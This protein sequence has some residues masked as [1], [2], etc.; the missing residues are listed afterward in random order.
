MNRGRNRTLTMRVVLL[1]MAAV[2][3][4]MTAE[5]QVRLVVPEESPSGPY[6]ARLERGVLLE[7]D[8]WVAI[9]F[10]RDPACVRPNFNLLNFF[11]FVNIPAIFFCP[12]TV[13]GFE[14]WDDP[15]TDAAPRQ[16]S[17]QGNGAVPVWFVST[18]DFHAALPGIT[19]TELLAMPSL[20]EGVATHFVETL[21]PLGGA[22]QN[23]LQIVASGE[24]P[25]GRTFQFVAVEAAGELRYVRIDVR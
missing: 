5:A 3:A 22:Q 20:M 14:L 2:L 10:Y 25:D 7:D 18:E 24:L 19:L 17:L 12:L 16:S 8:G 4:T 21:H 6:Y 15:A 23:S 11:D 13:N 1:A 9:P